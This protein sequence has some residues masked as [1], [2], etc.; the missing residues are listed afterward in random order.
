MHRSTFIKGLLGTAAAAAM[1][2][3][4]AADEPRRIG[5]STVIDCREAVARLKVPAVVLMRTPGTFPQQVLDENP[6]INDWWQD[7][8]RALA[9][10]FGGHL[11]AAPN[12]GHRIP[13]EDPGL[14]AEAVD[15][16]LREARSRA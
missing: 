12:A 6:G 15:R 11:V 2:P 8:H 13:Q 10:A 4:L 1:P 14:V 9:G 5:M 3:I 7:N 16:V